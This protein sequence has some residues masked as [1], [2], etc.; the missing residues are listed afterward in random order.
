MIYKSFNIQLIFSNHKTSLPGTKDGLFLVIPTNLPN[1]SPH[2][3]Y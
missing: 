2:Q 1:T 3:D